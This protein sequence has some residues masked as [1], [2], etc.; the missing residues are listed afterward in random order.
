LVERLEFS[1]DYTMVENSVDKL[2]EL[3]VGL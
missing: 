3:L 2:A 1:M